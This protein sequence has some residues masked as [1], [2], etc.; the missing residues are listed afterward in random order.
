MRGGQRLSKKNDKLTQPG[1]VLVL[2][3]NGRLLVRSE[4]DDSAEYERYRA[5]LPKKAPPAAKPAVNPRNRG[6]NAR[7][8]GQKRGARPN[9]GQRQPR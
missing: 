1:E 8:G 2:S 9:P 7:G 5:T 6:K 4:L 3:P